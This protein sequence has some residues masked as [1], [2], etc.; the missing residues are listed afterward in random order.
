VGS[1][2]ITRSIL[3][4][5]RAGDH[6]VHP[7][8]DS[9]M[10]DCIVVGGGLIGML[11]AR[12][13][14]DAGLSVTVLERGQA[15]RE[16]SWAGGGILS[17]LYPWRYPDAVTVLARQTQARYEDFAREL[18]EE[19]GIDPEWTRSGLL[20][21]DACEAEA[22]LAWAACQDAAVERL[23]GAAARA[24]EPA[25][26]GEPEL[27]LWMPAI[28]Q[29]RNP[30]LV[31]ALRES[32]RLRGVAIR[33]QMPVRAVL[34]DDRGVRGV[35]T[36]AGDLHADRVVIAGGA[37]S[38]G[39]MPAGGPVL[40]VAPVRG[41]MILFQARPGLMRRIVLSGG[42]YLIP[43]RDGR[44]LVG[45]TLEYTGFDKATTDSAREQ[46]YHAAMALVPALAEAPVEHHWAG[47]RP[48]SPTGIPLIGEHPACPGLFVNTGHFRNGVVLSLAACRLAADLVLGRT[49]CCDPA[50]YRLDGPAGTPV[51]GGFADRA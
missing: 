6:A 8:P 50:P 1:I 5:S 2:P 15:G 23:D 16:A 18:S 30:R 14:R 38:A 12:F 28:A 20:V 37:W 49:P 43:R 29:V 36:P 40:P 11:T 3:I 9:P 21:L 31:Q 41:Q 17:P 39:L 13:L 51:A 47:L 10:T 24:C 19:T 7:H 33:E 4:T 32:L 45:S 25:L 48:G 46:L 26:G 34:H 35:C 27:G 44:I 22:A 42:R